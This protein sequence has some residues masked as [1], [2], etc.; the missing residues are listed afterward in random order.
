[1]WLQQEPRLNFPIFGNLVNEIDFTVQEDRKLN[2]RRIA[3]PLYR[4]IFRRES[5]KSMLSDYRHMFDPQEFTFR[6]CIV[7]RSGKHVC[8]GPLEG[9]YRAGD[10]FYCHV[11]EWIARQGAPMVDGNLILISNRGR[12]DRWKSSPGNVTLRVSSD[13]SIAG[14]RTGFFSRPLNAGHKHLGFT[15]LNP[16]VEANAEWVSGL[17][18]INHSS[19]PTYEKWVR[20]SVRLYRSSGEYLEADFGDIAPHSSL[21]RSLLQLFPD[22]DSFLACSGGVGYTVTKLEGAS[23]ASL[24]V[25]RSRSGELCA[26]EH[27]R[28]AH[29]NV[30]NYL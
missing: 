22:A 28:P 16:R 21:E 14:Y 23:L 8:S 27:S 17:M 20:P 30:I 19:E 11:N 25:L 26:L 4:S 1:M 15:G 29:T 5:V 3:S 10:H 12:A 9:S 2:W 24:H 18:L 13:A 6:A 7:D